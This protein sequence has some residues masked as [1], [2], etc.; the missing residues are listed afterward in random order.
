MSLL[1][2]HII[3]VDQF[4]REQVEYV[5]DLA[6]RLEPIAKRQ[7]SCDLLKGAVLANMF[8]EASTRTRMSFGAAFNRLG[9]SI[10]D[11]TGFTFSSMAK[12]ESIYDTSRVISGYADVIVV[13]H[14]EEGSVAQFAKAT[15]VPIINGGDGIG[16]HPTQSLLDVYTMQK[17]FQRLG[18]S[19][20]GMKISLI[21]DLK[22]GRTV[23]SLVKMLS[24]FK[25]IEFEFI[26]PDNLG[27]PDSI[28]TIA[29]NRGHKISYVDLPSKGLVNSD[30]VYTTRIQ[31]ERFKTGEVPEGY[32]G[33]FC[34]NR[35]LI[36]QYCMPDT[37]IMHPLPRDSRPGSNDLH[38]DLN[39][40]HRLAVFRQADNGIPV[41][42][43]L[44]AAVLGIDNN[45]ESSF[46]PLTWQPVTS[47]GVDDPDFYKNNG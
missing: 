1:H 35:Q 22:H 17:E 39:T 26:A 41:R 4:D 14:P 37:I 8:F 5:I 34:I 45:I 16:E 29:D 27:I 11:T 13:R 24:L 23:H 44:F 42:M 47:I 25:D 33:E 2:Q 18:K 19:L 21:G 15:N 20:D 9:G 31:K 43:A 12:G 38:N 28:A 6:S 32:S 7:M 30:V 40:D 36:N 3:S 10:I 46:K